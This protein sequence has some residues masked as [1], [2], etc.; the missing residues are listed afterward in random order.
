M[1]ECLEQTTPAFAVCFCL[2]FIL[3]FFNPASVAGE[4]AIQRPS[5]MVPLDG[6]TNLK[7]RIS[8][9]GSGADI[10]E[11][12][13]DAMMKMPPAQRQTAWIEVHNLVAGMKTDSMELKKESTVFR[14]R[15]SGKADHLEFSKAMDNNFQNLRKKLL[16]IQKKYAFLMQNKGIQVRQFEATPLDIS[17]E[18]IKSKREEVESKFAAGEQA[19]NSDYNTLIEII[20]T[21]NEQM[22]IFNKSLM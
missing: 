11:R 22:G 15:N 4:P 20:K 6:G 3:F 13:L 19:R 9:F 21:M 14:T 18:D 16:E 7:I 17:K 5:G 2:M 12:K 8:K 10:L 1:K